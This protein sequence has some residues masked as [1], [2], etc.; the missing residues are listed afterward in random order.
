MTDEPIVRIAARG[1]GMTASGRHSPLSAPGDLLAL[2]GTLTRGPHHVD[3]ACRHFPACGGCQLQH[4]DNESY[5]AFVVDRVASALAAQRF[6]NADIRP[7]HL[8]PPQTRRRASLTAERRGKQI[9]LGFNAAQSNRIVDL[10]QCPILHPELE[11]LV[12]P[13]RRLLL[14]L[15]ADR[16]AATVQ[17]TRADQGVD[18]LI[19]NVEADG[20]D[21]V[22]A[23]SDFAQ[24]HRLARLSLDDGYGPTVRWEPEPVT[25]TLGATFTVVN[26]CRS[27]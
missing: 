9:L 21:A 19:S 7:A 24:T 11:A 10:S 13:L 16:K 5:A 18:L 27:S 15:M 22:M 2:D 1:D 14:T 8:S 26:T 25:I 4:I 20:L 23:L 3:P 6:A 12:K 17:M